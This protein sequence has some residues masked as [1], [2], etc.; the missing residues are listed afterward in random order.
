MVARVDHHWLLVFLDGRPEPF[1]GVVHGG[2]GR[3]TPAGQE[4]DVV[5]VAFPTVDAVLVGGSIYLRH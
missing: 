4:A 3:V 2:A 1:G 5:F